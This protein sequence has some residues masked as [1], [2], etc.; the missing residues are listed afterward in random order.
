MFSGPLKSFNISG[1][2]S[3]TKTLTVSSA[4]IA[5]VTNVI[6]SPKWATSTRVLHRFIGTFRS[7]FSLPTRLVSLINLRERQR[8]C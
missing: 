6:F 5:P 1:F 4:V 2:K 7:R 8:L 3:V